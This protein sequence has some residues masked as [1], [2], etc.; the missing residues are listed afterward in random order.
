ML[1]LAPG[2]ARSINYLDYGA[3]GFIIAQEISHIVNQF[4]SFQCELLCAFSRDG[5]L[6]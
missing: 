5:E 4:V 3:T 6:N 1:Q 2:V